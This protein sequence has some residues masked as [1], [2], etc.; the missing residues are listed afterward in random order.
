MDNKVCVNQS[1]HPYEA[2]YNQLIVDLLNRSGVVNQL[3]HLLET[4]SKN[5]SSCTFALN[6][7]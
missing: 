2:D 7:V 5:K 4:L 1:E 6:G 3:S